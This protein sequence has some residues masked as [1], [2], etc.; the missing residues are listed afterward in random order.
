MTRGSV[1]GRSG[2]DRREENLRR[3]SGA[4]F[5]PPL[6][7]PCLKML[8]QTP[9]DS[10]AGWQDDNHN[11]IKVKKDRKINQTEAAAYGFPLRAPRYEARNASGGGSRDDNNGKAPARWPIPRPRRLA[12]WACLAPC[13]AAARGKAPRST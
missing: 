11:R 10:E 4:S 6:P 5:R 9:L 3:I 2:L 1:P 8:A 12:A 13:A 7:A